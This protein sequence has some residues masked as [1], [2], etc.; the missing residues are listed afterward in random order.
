LN[1]IQY[2]KLKPIEK[3]KLAIDLVRKMDQKIRPKASDGKLG[4]LVEFPDTEER[5][6]IVIGDM[7]AAKR[8]LRQILLDSGNLGKLRDNKLVIVFLGDLVHDDRTG[9]MTEMDT[10]I[11]IL[12]I[13][14][15]LIERYPGNIVYILG[16]HDTFSEN[17]SKLG[18][19]QG[20]EFRRA[21]V[22]RHGE[23]YADVL[24]EFFDSL[25]LFVKHKNFLATH[26][27]PPRGGI[28]REELININHFTNLKWQLIW[29]RLNETRSTP[30][31]KEYGN[32]DIVEMRR[33]LGCPEDIPVVVGHNPMWKWG[34]DDSIWINPA[35]TKNH[36]IVYSNLPKKCPYLSFNDS[37]K[38]EVKY[39]DLKLAVRRFVLDDYA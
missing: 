4:G 6:F 16:N 5:E 28:T 30:S 33:L 15:H 20:V 37:M 18:I 23:K 22:A 21:I 25:P 24:Q 14:F 2:S 39:A 3:L 9:H 34:G 32:E 1:S 11:E 35:G 17:L 19:Q 27:G 38:Y 26:A 31:M 13:V 29:N 10:S 36:V 12:D 7:H 8:N